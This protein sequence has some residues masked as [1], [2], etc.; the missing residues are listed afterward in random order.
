MARSFAL[1]ALTI[2]IVAAGCWRGNE[3]GGGLPQAAG[4]VLPDAGASSPGDGLEVATFAGGCFWCIDAPFEDLDGVKKVVS[5]YSGGSV[6]N[7]TYELV[8]TG[9]TGHLETVQVTFDPA[10]IS[11][12]EI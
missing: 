2:M 3:S 4:S 7:P 10:M 5:G 11:Y 6:K 9:S 1:M 8:S 12:S